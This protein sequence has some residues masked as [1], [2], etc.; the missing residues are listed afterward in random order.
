[1]VRRRQVYKHIIRETL[2]KILN[3]ALAGASLFAMSMA[4]GTSYAQTFDI[5]S[6]SA[7]I[8][9]ANFPASNAIDGDLNSRSR[10]A[11]NGNPERLTLDLGTIRRVDDIQIAFTAGNRITY[12]FIVEGR[13]GTSGSWTCLLYTSPSPRDGLLSRMPSSA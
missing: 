8:S 6:A 4:G 2:M 12:P 1:M 3:K 10:W 9:G 7:N 5:Q 11:G 13:S